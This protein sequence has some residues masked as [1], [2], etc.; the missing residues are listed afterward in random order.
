MKRST[1]D[2]NQAGYFYTSVKEMESYLSL[3]CKMESVIFLMK[4]TR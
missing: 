3:I 2:N 1:D 4:E